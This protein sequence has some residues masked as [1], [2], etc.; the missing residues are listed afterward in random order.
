MVLT[1]GFKFDPEAS[2]T[3]SF[4]PCAEGGGAG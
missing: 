4:S 3:T 2:E 1:T